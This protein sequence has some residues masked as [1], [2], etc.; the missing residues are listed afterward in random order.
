MDDAARCRV[1]LER[2]AGVPKERRTARFRAVLC[3]VWGPGPA[4]VAFFEAGCEGWI[5]FAPRGTG[6]FGY[7]PVFYLRGEGGTFLERSMAELSPAEKNAV[8]HRGRALAL[9]RQALA[10]WE[11][12]VDVDGREW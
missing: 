6:G 5:G 4:E 10:E 12:G 2:L 3:L 1:L 8:S 7:D 11:Q 9:L